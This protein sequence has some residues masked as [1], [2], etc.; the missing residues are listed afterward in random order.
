MAVLEQPCAGAAQG[1]PEWAFEELRSHQ[2]DENAAGA[3]RL[4]AV[5]AAVTARMRALVTRG[6]R[7]D[8]ARSA[9]LA[10]VATGA[11]CTMHVAE[12]HHMIGRLLNDHLP[13]VR[14]AAF[15]GLLDYRR[16]QTIYHYVGD[17]APRLIRL[18]EV[19][20]LA[21]ARHQPPAALARDL[22]RLILAAD[23]D[24]ATTRQKRQQARRNVTRTPVRDGMENLRAYLPAAD[25]VAVDSAI[26]RVARTCCQEDPRDAG[27]RRA[28]AMVAIA[29]GQ[30]HLA[31][32]CRGGDCAAARPAPAQAAGS[33]AA[34]SGVPGSDAMNRP[35]RGTTPSSGVPG[36]PSTH[37]YVH[38]DLQTLAHLAHRPAHLVGHGLIPADYARML[39]DNATWQLLFTE[40]RSLAERW[41]AAHPTGRTRRCVDTSCTPQPDDGGGPDAAGVA[42]AEDCADSPEDIDF[43]GGFDTDAVL[44]MNAAGEWVQAASPADTVG[45]DELNDPDYLHY[46]EEEYRKYCLARRGL[47]QAGR[48]IA[49]ATGGG[50]E[51]G[52]LFGAVRHAPPT[53]LRHVRL[54]VGRP[55]PVISDGLLFD[56]LTARLR[57]DPSLASGVDPAGHGAHTEPP[58]GAVTYR[59]RRAV[60]RLA[61]LRDG[62]C[63]FPGCTIN[64]ARCQIDHIVAFDHD[65]PVAGGWSIEE[66]LH[67]LCAQHHQLKTSG[68]WEV[69]RLAGDAELWTSTVTAQQMVSIPDGYQR[70]PDEIEID[71]RPRRT[72]HDPPPGTPRPAPGARPR[73]PG[74]DDAPF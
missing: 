49:G 68:Y 33:G 16:L 25:A 44:Q 22:D 3:R 51:P 72:R 24:A 56:H 58:P 23:P 31:C 46:L 38:V 4:I 35:E 34:G 8:R 29:L 62:H 61:R 5:D 10:E 12:T 70:R 52:A 47:Q 74:Q 71:P 21:A 60:A 55:I 64:A 13:A 53:P 59:P 40:A 15:A 6:D 37:V 32:R 43:T 41:S 73:A 54:P 45:Y 48:D 63:R 42:E 11:R 26:D 67:C 65:D 9:A 36:K 19:D 2:R 30:S 7:L 39:A 18:L 50:H 66:N 57:E 17:L 1:S 28:D 69:T 20:I 14:D 27:N